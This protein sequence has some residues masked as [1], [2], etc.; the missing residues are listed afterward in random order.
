[1]NNRNAIKFRAFI[2][3]EGYDEAIKK[4]EDKH[5]QI[6]KPI[7][8][9]DDFERLNRMLIDSLN[10]HTEFTFK[11]FNGGFINEAV[12]VVTSFNN[13]SKILTINDELRFKI[14]DLIDM[15]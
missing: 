4:I 9:E 8:S 3:H 13:N 15:N 5:K 14:D 11:F 6:E 12:G 10:N 7:L 1:M 2:P